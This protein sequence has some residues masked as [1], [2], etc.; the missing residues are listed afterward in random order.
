MTI[1]NDQWNGENK[2]HILSKLNYTQRMSVQTMT[3]QVH[4]NVCGK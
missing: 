1:Y 4:V 3:R 2:Q